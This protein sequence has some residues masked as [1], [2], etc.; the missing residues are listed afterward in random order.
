M[1]LLTLWTDLIEK[2]CLFVDDYDY[3]C[4]ELENLKVNVWGSQNDIEL[5]YDML[6]ISWD[7]L[8]L[9]RN[10]SEISYNFN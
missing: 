2:G 4:F 3:D 5:F 9:S 6:V 10:S 7:S 1:I 8:F